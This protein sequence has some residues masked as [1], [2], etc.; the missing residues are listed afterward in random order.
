MSDDRARRDEILETAGT[1]FAS[2][3]LRT[4]LAEI[5]DACGI[6]PGSLYHHFDSKEAIIFELV[7]RYREDL[8]RVAK[9]ALEGRSESVEDRIVRLGEAIAACAVRHRAA[10]LYTLY[11]PPT[12]AGEELR[13]LARQ[14]PV[15]IDAAMLEIL[16]GGA[17]T[18]AIRSGIDLPLFAERIC[19]S[20][21]H[22]GVGV[23]HRSRAGRHLPAEKCRLLLHGL[24]VKMPTKASLDRSDAMRAANA[25]IATWD[26]D[27]DGDDRVLQLRAVA[28]A[29]FG[30]HGYE[31]TTIRDIAKAAGMSTGSVY[32]LFAS[33]DELLI[34]I[35]ET[36]GET[37]QTAWEDVLEA[38]ATS[39]EKLDGLMW[40]NTNLLDRFSDEFKIQLAW[41]RQ[42]PPTSVD[43]GIS[44]GHQIQRLKAL[45]NA[46]IEAG[47][48]QVEGPADVNRARSLYELMLIPVSIVRSAGVRTSQSLARETLLRGA[49]KRS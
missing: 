6:L 17:A 24:A 27:D 18:G 5:A 30:R 7:Q 45:L 40:V 10:L 35:M 13:E 22:V 2:S 31:S 38:D 1:L 9:E 36:F 48:L 41:F 19:Q 25:V 3:G 34:S 23:F 8:D 16:E 39:V 12:A 46:G 32:R 4:T 15:A 42:S 28:R 20:M 49:G 26:R 29:E 37:S 44:F 21:L 11:E 14:A 33:K 47:E 43:L